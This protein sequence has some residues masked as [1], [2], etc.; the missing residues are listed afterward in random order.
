MYK[1][2]FSPPPPPLLPCTWYICIIKVITKK[3][4]RVNEGILAIYRVSA[5]GNGRAQTKDYLPC[6]QRLIVI[7]VPGEHTRKSG[8]DLGITEIQ[9]PSLE[10][11]QFACYH[12]H[13]HHQPIIR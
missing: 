8:G 11:M 6:G 7:C 12:P 5:A 2:T 3:H 13:C 10:S 1:H 9:N 4:I